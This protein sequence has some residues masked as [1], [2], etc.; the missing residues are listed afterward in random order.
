MRGK[1]KAAENKDEGK[2]EVEKENLSVH[3]WK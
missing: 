2:R 3:M 1:E